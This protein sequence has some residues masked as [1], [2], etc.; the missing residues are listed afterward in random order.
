MLEGLSVPEATIE[1]IGVLLT[2]CASHAV[3]STNQYR[4]NSQFIKLL[5]HLITLKFLFHDLK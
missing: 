4:L 2:L 3:Q 5:F 1:Q